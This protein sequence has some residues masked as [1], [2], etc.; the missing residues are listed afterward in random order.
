[1]PMNLQDYPDD[2]KLR[3]RF[4][5]QVRSG[6]RC[7]RCGVENYSV[8]NGSKIILTVAHLYDRDPMSA[9]LLNLAAMC[10]RCHLAYDRERCGQDK[11][12]LWETATRCPAS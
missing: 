9:G 1:M 2:W 3:S 12:G 4:I 8:R 6:G 10:Q 11:I 5:R 7:E